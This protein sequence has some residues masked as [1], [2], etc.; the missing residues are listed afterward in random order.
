[1]KAREARTERT[2]IA[3]SFLD[4]ESETGEGARHGF[5]IDDFAGAADAGDS[6]GVHNDREIGELM[7]AGKHEGL[8]VGAFLKFA[9][10]DDDIDAGV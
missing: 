9:I 6:V 1:M 8:P 7:V 3:G 10:A 2:G 4:R 5:E